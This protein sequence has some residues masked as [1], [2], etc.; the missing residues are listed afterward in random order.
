MQIG[1]KIKNLRL[2]MGLTQEE[3]AERSDLTKGFISQ[4]EHDNAS[5]SVDTLENIVGALGTTMADFF[6][7]ENTDPVVFH[8]E[9]AFSGVYEQWGMEMR[10]IVATAQKHAMEPVLLE[11]APGGRSK[12][13][14]PFEGESFGYV[15]AGRPTLQYGGERYELKPTD[16]FY[17]DADRAFLLENPGDTDARVLWV[18]TPPSF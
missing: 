13:Y 17:F 6:V 10:W 3:L 5:P 1:E 15:L 4:L 14:D 9:E 11:L 8:H 2:R 18:V 12:E 16:S 7:E